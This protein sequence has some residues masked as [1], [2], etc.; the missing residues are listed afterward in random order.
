MKGSS[1]WGSVRKI[2]SLAQIMALLQAVNSP[3]ETNQ[4]EAMRKSLVEQHIVLERA[5]L[6]GSQSSF[7]SLEKIRESLR[8]LTEDNLSFLTRS[9]F[10]RTE[11]GRVRL[12]LESRRLLRLRNKGSEQKVRKKVLKHIL[13]SPYRAYMGFLL[14]LQRIGGEF[15]LP[16]G[17]D[18]RTRISGLRRKLHR[19]GF[20]TDIASFYTA[21]D[22]FY[23]FGLVNH[24]TDE[25]KR[26]ESIFQTCTIARRTDSSR[27][28]KHRVRVREYY[29][30]YDPILPPLKFCNALIEGYRTLTNAWSKWVSLIRL[31][32]AVTIRLRIPDECFDANLTRVLKSGGCNTFKVDGSTGYRL[33]DRTYGT[34]VK[35]MRMPLTSGGRPIQYVAIAREQT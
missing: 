4:E 31:R 7:R 10:V 30:C 2:R 29:I 35:S 32:D 18:K 14:N 24:V 9:S 5:R 26:L 1:E 6:R 27:R 23:D 28:F 17:G 15:T 8:A 22:L 12:S 21:R 34:I 25:S 20:K 19:L 13:V 16:A 11:K 3:R 33:G